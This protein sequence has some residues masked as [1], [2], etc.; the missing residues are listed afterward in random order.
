MTDSTL[1]V[2]KGTM[3]TKTRFQAVL[4]E[5]VDRI[6]TPEKLALHLEGLGEPCAPNSIRNWLSGERR[7]HRQKAV[8]IL[9][10]LKV[11]EDIC[12][13]IR[14]EYTRVPKDTVVI[15]FAAEYTRVPVLEATI[16]AGSGSLLTSRAAQSHLAFRTDWLRSVG[17]PEEMVAMRA[18][19]DSME[20]LIMDGDVVLVDTSQTEPLIGR[21]FAIAV[22]GTLKVK[23]LST[24]SR[25]P[26]QDT[27]REELRDWALL[28][29]NPDY[30]E[31]IEY[32]PLST[33]FALVG[34][35]VWLGRDITRL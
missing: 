17:R 8:A 11:P 33:Y 28:S 4:E 19:G 32:V 21:I 7:P 10:A 22:D 15:P 26:P 6:G 30:H 20:P 34:R 27:P 24:I 9:R 2:Y 31:P 12:Q 35:A 14:E 23:R 29:E 18:Y 13:E 3:K 25:N 5:W 16:S 1:Q